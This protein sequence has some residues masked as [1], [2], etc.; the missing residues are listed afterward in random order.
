MKLRAGLCSLLYGASKIGGG[1]PCSPSGPHRFPH[2]SGRVSRTP[3]LA[4][5]LA[6]G[7]QQF[8]QLAWRYQYGENQAVTFDLALPWIRIDPSVKPAGGAERQPDP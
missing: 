2:P 5:R 1:L 7:G 3:P 4:A 6:E 8:Q